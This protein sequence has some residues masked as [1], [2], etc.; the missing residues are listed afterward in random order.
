MSLKV[1]ENPGLLRDPHSKAIIS[2]DNDAFNAYK[3]QRERLLNAQESST[4]HEQEIQTLK[5]DVNEIKSLLNIIINKINI[6]HK[7]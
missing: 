5:N 1:Q 2:V 6:E 4:K 3:M 7:E